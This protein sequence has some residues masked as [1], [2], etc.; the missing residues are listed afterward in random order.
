VSVVA[1]RS[2]GAKL[3]L[4]NGALGENRGMRAPRRDRRRLL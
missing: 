1:T 3:A 2:G 4:A